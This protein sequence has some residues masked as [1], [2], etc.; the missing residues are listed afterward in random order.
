[1]MTWFNWIRALRVQQ[2]IASLCEACV[3]EIDPLNLSKI[4]T[5]QNT[6]APV[7]CWTWQYVSAGKIPR[8]CWSKTLPHVTSAFSTLFA[9]FFPLFVLLAVA[10]FP[11]YPLV[12]VVRLL[13]TSGWAVP[14]TN[15]VSHSVTWLNETK[16]ITDCGT[17][18]WMLCFCLNPNGN[19]VLS[20]SAV[21]L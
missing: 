17:G 19:I 11:S 9:V 5:T 12:F 10:I 15:C 2:A 4:P 21:G 7:L 18:L 13:P 6:L 3:T 20:K 1:M 16:L 14:C 8:H